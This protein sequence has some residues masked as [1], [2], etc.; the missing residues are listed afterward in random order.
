MVPQSLTIGLYACLFLISGFGLVQAQIVYRSRPQGPPTRAIG[1]LGQTHAVIGGVRGR[2]EVG[3]GRKV[4]VIMEATPQLRDRLSF[5]HR[6]S[7]GGPALP[8]P[9]PPA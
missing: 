2:T 4:T 5:L 3:R 1:E 8:V 7:A 6:V 9:L